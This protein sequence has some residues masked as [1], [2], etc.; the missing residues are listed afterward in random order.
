M[1]PK[2]GRPKTENPK[3]IRFSIRLDTETDTKL[4]EYCSKNNISKGE[5]IR[6]GI[7]LLLSEKSAPV[8]PTTEITSA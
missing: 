6:K 1:S 7:N 8:L 5:A 4:N 3:D 2:T